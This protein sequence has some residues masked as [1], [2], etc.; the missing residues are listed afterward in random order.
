[1]LEQIHN[2]K[3][4]WLDNNSL[5][6]IPGVRECSERHRPRFCFCFFLSSLRLILPLSSHL[7]PPAVYRKTSPAAV[8]GLSQESHR[9]VGH[10]HFRLRGLRGP[11][12]V[13]QHVAAAPG[14]HRYTHRFTHTNTVWNHDR[15]GWFQADFV[16]AIIEPDYLTAYRWVA[17]SSDIWVFIGPAPP[18]RSLSRHNLE[19]LV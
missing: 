13:L 6:S 18:K 2:L 12:A 16:V 5:Q 8:L 15:T 4:L 10:G 19:C 17:K 9:D 11:A 7:F 14:H 1:M 3:E